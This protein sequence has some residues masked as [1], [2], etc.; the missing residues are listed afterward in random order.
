MKFASVLVANRGEIALRVMRTAKRMGLRTIAVYS[1]ADR[2]ALHVRAADAAFHVGGS[3]PRDSYLNIDS[4]LAAAKAA[5]ADAVH[6]GYG[7]L[8]ESERFAIEVQNH[9]LIWI[10]PPAAALRAMGD[11]GEAK[12][13]AR[14]AG[15]PALPEY[16]THGKL[17]FPLLVK[18]AAGGGGRGMRLVRNAAE[19]PA[20]LA[21]ARSEAE[22]AFGDGRLLLEPAIEAAR[23][24]EVQVFADMLGGVVHLGE[25]DCS[26]Q[27]RH[28]KLIEESPAPALDAKLRAA[29][30][31]AALAVARAAGYVGAGTVEFLLDQG[32]RFWFMEM[33]TRLQVEHTVTEACTGIDLVEWQLRVAAGEP[34]PARQDEIRFA[35]H[36][37]EARLCAEDPARAFLPQA[38]VLALWQPPAGV[39]VEHALASG[40]VIAPHYDSMI[41]KLIAHAPSRDEAR[42]Q[43]ARALDATV[44]LGLPTNKA[45]LAAV[46]RDEAFAAGKATTDFLA[47][48]GFESAKPDLQAAAPLF[49]GDYGEWTGWSN[50]P[51]HCARVKF[52]EKVLAFNAGGTGAKP[53]HVVEGDTVHFVQRGHSFTLRNALYDPPQKRG[54]AAVD[55]RLAAPMNGRV[56]AVNGKVGDTIAA[57]QP[58]VVLEAMKMEHGLELP[59]SIRITSIHVRTGVQVA[60][61]NLLVEFEP[62]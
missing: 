13:I 3:S 8:A 55:G 5:G 31:A 12:R 46:L 45:F 32:G 42:E 30:G 43:L 51:A 18:A 17:E 6:P 1:D 53:T 14:A 38:G 25:R 40:A 49:A 29:T 34:L 57:G 15:V 47:R 50:N 61:G 21:S 60:P 4:V 16:V 35:G 11:K 22:H 39:R 19:L 24:V 27:R 7:F 33:N 44:A 62:A 48:F 2:D 28:Q 59:F 37:I 26:V 58:L 36:A 10:G 20:A 52:D 56:V 9:E 23:H 54:V 41:A